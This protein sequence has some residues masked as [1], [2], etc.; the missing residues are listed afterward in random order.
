MSPEI[1][2]TIQ[3]IEPIAIAA[4][5]PGAPTSP[6]ILRIRVA[7]RRVAIAIPETGLLELPTKP[8]IREET[9]AKKNPK[10]T[11]IIAPTKETGISGTSHTKRVKTRMAI[12]VT[13]IFISWAVRSVPFEP[14]MLKPFI[15][16]RKVRTI[17]G[18]DLIRLIIPP[19][20]SAPAPIYRM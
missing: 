1:A 7:I 19:A 8:T 17:R 14:L 4:C 2:A 5:I 20:A 10:I 16:S 11:T 9:V 15:E 18:R 12:K 13:V 6:Q 3:I